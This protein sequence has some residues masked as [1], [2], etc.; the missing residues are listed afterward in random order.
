MSASNIRFGP[1]TTAIELM[2]FGVIPVRNGNYVLDIVK[3]IS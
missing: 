3:T 2:Q 1:F